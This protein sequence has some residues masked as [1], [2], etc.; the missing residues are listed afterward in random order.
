MR[1]KQLLCDAITALKTWTANSCETN[2]YTLTT[3]ST[4]T[5]FCRP[6]MPTDDD[7]YCETYKFWKSLTGQFS[8]STVSIL[9]WLL[10]KCCEESNV[11]FTLHSH[12][13]DYIYSIMTTPLLLYIKQQTTEM[14]FNI[15]TY[16]KTKQNKTNRGTINC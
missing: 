14:A 10:N 7:K 2:S 3:V 11:T 9:A 12:D 15:S 13:T 6:M 8:H 1:S 4:L 5:T 16:I